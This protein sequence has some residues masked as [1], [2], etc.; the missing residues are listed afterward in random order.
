MSDSQEQSLPALW[1]LVRRQGMPLIAVAPLLVLFSAFL[2]FEAA[3]DNCRTLEAL[4]R[5][6]P[7]IAEAATFCPEPDGKAAAAAER[8]TA[9][10][11][12]ALA[13]LSPVIDAGS[14]VTG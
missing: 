6:L 9:P 13:D 14:R 1:Q 4:G 7:S 11:V 12:P 3:F 10:A 8:E 2:L 5:T